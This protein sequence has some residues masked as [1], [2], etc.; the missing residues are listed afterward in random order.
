M[1]TSVITG[2]FSLLIYT[3]V[4]SRDRQRKR[5]GTGE[6]RG[7]GIFITDYIVPEIMPSTGNTILNNMGIT[8]SSVELIVY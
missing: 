6:R 3:F 7:C 4:C 1:L 8:F 2:E 5:K